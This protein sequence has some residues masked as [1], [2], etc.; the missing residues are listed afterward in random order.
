MI[1]NGQFRETVEGDLKHH[2]QDIFI[3]IVAIFWDKTKAQKV[4]IARLTK[5][6]GKR[7]DNGRIMTSQF[8]TFP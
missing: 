2:W 1:G 6:Y 4:Q 8:D 5:K 7:Q 3:E